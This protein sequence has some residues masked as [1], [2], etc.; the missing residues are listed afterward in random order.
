MTVDPDRLRTG[1]LFE[2]HAVVAGV[3]IELLAEV[4]ID[5]NLLRLRD[6]AVHPV[7]VEHA[8]VGG[9][10]LMRAARAAP[11]S[12]HPGGRLHPAKG[13]RN[14]PV[15]STLRRI[16]DLTIDLERQAR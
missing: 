4:E 6:V 8:E 3:P 9:G 1:E 2:W 16:V 14:P 10:A 12:R 5:G 11:V 15:R 13:D 7:G